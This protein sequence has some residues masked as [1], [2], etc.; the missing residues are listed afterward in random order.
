[1]LGIIVLDDKEHVVA[2]ITIPEHHRAHVEEA[3]ERI[4]NLTALAHMRVIEENKRD[5]DPAI[6]SFLEVEGAGKFRSLHEVN[7]EG[8]R[9]DDEAS[10]EIA[11]KE[12]GIA[13]EILF[14]LFFAVFLADDITMGNRQERIDDGKDRSG[15]LFAE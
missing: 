7:G 6:R 5:Q 1:M 2:E 10:D 14:G 4:G 11:R 3:K 12:I 15:K 9:C 8:N 13:F